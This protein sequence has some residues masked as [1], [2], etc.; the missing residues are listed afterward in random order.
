LFAVHHS[1]T[2]ADIFVHDLNSQQIRYYVGTAS[3]EHQHS[4]YLYG[5]IS[6]STATG[7]SALDDIDGDGLQ[8]LAV[9]SP[10]SG[11]GAVDILLSSDIAV[12]SST[13]A[14]SWSLAGEDSGDQLGT[15]IASAGDINDDGYGDLIVGAPSHDDTASNAGAA[16]VF[17]GQATPSGSMTGA[18]ATAE[19]AGELRNN[20]AG[21][22]VAG[23]GD[24]DQDG[25]LD[26]GVGAPSYDYG[27]MD[28]PGA[29]YIVY[30]PFTGYQSLN[31]VPGRVGG[32]NTNGDLGAAMAGP[33]DLNGDGFGDFI[34]GEP[35][36]DTA[37]DDSAGTVWIYWGQGL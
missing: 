15:A 8:E 2:V 13:S 3:G 6:A 4:D 37:A 24:V 30:G 34:V 25:H 23:L 35:G 5:T 12:A 9:Q 18:D 36:Y 16:Y 1:G 29:A 33:A 10:D 22:S 19:V 21:T 17:L 11:S 26:I 32:S 7:S 27:D 31:D 20:Y 14:A 28:N